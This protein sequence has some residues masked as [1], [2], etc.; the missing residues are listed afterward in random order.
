[1]KIFVKVKPLSKTEKIEK[2]DENNFIIFVKEPPI[3]GKAN[4]AIIKALSEYFNTP[5]S[6]IKII[7][8]LTSKNKIVHIN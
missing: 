1:M 3:Q 8:G 6:N 4:T 7:S 2:I 5:K